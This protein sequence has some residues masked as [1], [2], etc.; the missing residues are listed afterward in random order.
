MD[1]GDRVFDEAHKI[2]CMSETSMFCRD[3]VA[4]LFLIRKI[5]SLFNITF[6]I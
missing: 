2:P 4:S 3:C 6:H 1:K 5:D